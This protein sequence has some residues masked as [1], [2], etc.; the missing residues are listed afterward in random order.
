M[1]AETTTQN[2][3]GSATT[4]EVLEGLNDLLQLDHDAVGAYEIAIAKLDNREYA[5]QIRGYKRDHERHIK[6]L[7]EMIVSLGGT[8]KNEPHGTGPLKQALQGLGAVAGDKGVLVAWRANE[9]QVRTR[10]DRYAA[11]ANSWPPAVKRLVDENAL[12]E[13]GHYRWVAE[14]LES[15]G[16]GSGEG[17]EIHLA[18]KAREES[19]ALRHRARGYGN[20]IETR[21]K[22]EPAQTL[23]ASFAVGFIIGRILR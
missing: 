16:V 6:N 7:N 15:L 4:A 20:D 13:E 21:M 14:L 17:A 18:D 9:L 11:E 12:D 10:Y 19:A 23:L 2:R 5:S 22:A 1:A 3:P 8:P